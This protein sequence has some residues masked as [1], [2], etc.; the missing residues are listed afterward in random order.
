MVG[1]NRSPV[2][3]LVLTVITCGIYSL[4]WHYVVGQEINA[5]LGREAVK[6][7]YVFL[8]ILCFPVLYYYM[9]TVDK[10]ML[11]LAAQRGKNYNSNFVLWIICSVLA[12][13]GVYIEM[14]QVQ[15]TLNDIWSTTVV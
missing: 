2:M 1:T 13:V 15:D 4:Y 14:F 5:A 3:V 7:M 9:Y 10:A 6:P 11:E 8:A 12:G